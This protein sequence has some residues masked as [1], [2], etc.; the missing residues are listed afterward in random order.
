MAVVSQIGSGAYLQY[1]KGSLN[2]TKT[3]LELTKQL[4]KWEMFLN[5]SVTCPFT[6]V[7]Y[8]NVISDDSHS[9]SNQHTHTSTLRMYVLPKFTG[10][11]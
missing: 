6:V 5:C 8:D 2:G 11:E 7:F 3:K 9:G 4:N 1:I 10:R